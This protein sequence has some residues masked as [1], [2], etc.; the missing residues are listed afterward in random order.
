M[1]NSIIKPILV[2]VIFLVCG[3][4]SVWL[5]GFLSLSEAS[6]MVLLTLSTIFSILL[7]SLSQLKSFSITKGELILQEVKDSEAA[8]KDLAI[9]TMDLVEAATKVL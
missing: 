4:G 8:V 6:F 2:V 1:V 9:A 5:K 3:I 7:P